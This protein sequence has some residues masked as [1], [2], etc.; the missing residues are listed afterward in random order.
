[1]E[2]GV[3]G[4]A[5]QGEVEDERSGIQ[6][7]GR[8]IANFI[9]GPLMGTSSQESRTLENIGLTPGEAAAVLGLT[10]SRFTD[11]PA[12]HTER[13]AASL[14]G[15]VTDLFKSPIANAQDESD[16]LDRKIHILQDSLGLE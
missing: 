9:Q 7:V 11:Y 13:A 2:A 14:G 15:K 5:I 12:S 4:S 3:R 1:M 16:D 10:D 8:N 6:G